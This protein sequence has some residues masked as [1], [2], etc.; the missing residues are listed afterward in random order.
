MHQVILEKISK[1]IK[2]KLDEKEAGK[3][4]DNVLE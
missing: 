4:L 3:L 2:I 1:E